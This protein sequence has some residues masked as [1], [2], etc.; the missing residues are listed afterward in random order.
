VRVALE[1]VKLRE[2]VPT[3]VSLVECS[4]FECL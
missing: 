2:R 1:A 4:V 3:E